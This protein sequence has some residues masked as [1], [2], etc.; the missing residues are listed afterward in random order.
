MY[1]QL[2]ISSKLGPIVIIDKITNV[3]IHVG[4]SVDKGFKPLLGKYQ[5]LSVYIIVFMLHAH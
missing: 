5:A 3:S 2:S 1:E 4:L